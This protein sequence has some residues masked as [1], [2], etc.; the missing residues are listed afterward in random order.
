[1]SSYSLDQWVT[2]TWHT[3]MQCPEWENRIY[4]CIVRVHTYQNEEI[5]DRIDVI[6]VIRV[7]S[8]EIF[9]L[10]LHTIQ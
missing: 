10:G 1:M 6:H 9:T 2:L 4:V 7:V 3:C 5:I 8:R